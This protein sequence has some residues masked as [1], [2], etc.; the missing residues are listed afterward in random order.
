M[1]NFFRDYYKKY[2]ELI[3]DEKVEAN[4]QSFKEL[5]ENVK[6][7]KSKIMLA[8]NG[9]SASIASHGAVDFTKQGGVRAITFNE[10][11]L[12]TCFSNDYGYNNWISEAINFYHNKDDIV[13]LISV[14][15]ESENVIRAAYRSKELGLKVVTFSGRNA[16][17]R[18]KQL[19]DINFWVNSDAYNIVE[20]IHMVWLTS[21]I[22]AVIGKS[23]YEVS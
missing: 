14:S 7:S 12:I 22:D 8:G 18:L 2:H 17:N 10:A 20:G 3:F 1:N 11:N 13:I 9:A 23:E 6:N 5:A 15:G 21:V 16:S 19:G 4:L